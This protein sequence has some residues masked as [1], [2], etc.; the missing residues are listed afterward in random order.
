MTEYS[1]VG[2][3]QGFLLPHLTSRHHSYIPSFMQCLSL[4][5]KL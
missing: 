3:V 5:N 2:A 4:A 1:V